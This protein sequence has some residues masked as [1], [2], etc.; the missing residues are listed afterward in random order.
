[1]LPLCEINGKWKNV[2]IFSDCGFL[3]S[4]IKKEKFYERYLCA[5][6]RKRKIFASKVRCTFNKI[7]VFSEFWQTVRWLLIYRVSGI[8]ELKL[9]RFLKSNLLYKDSL[10][11]II[12]IQI[13]KTKISTDIKYKTVLR[14]CKLKSFKYN[15]L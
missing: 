3:P 8:W 13:L 5:F 6:Q 4:V 7:A 9:K 10:K 12:F 14:N 2:E 1:M 11:R 15:V